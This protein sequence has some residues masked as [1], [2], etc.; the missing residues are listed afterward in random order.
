MYSF[1][2]YDTVITR[3]V[4]NP[5]GIWELMSLHL[6]ESIN[7]LEVSTYIAMNFTSIRESA[8]RQARKCTSKEVTIADIYRVLGNNYFLPKEALERLIL[9][10]MQIERD[11]AIL[12]TETFE[13]IKKLLKGGEEVI[14]ISDMY[15]PKSFFDQVFVKICPELCELDL[16]VSCDVG[17]T[18]ASGQMYKYIAGERNISYSDWNHEGDNISSDIHVAEL[19]GI[20]TTQYKRKMPINSLQRIEKILINSHPVISQLLLGLAKNIDSQKSSAY[21][22]GYSFV[23]IALYSYVEW[24][25]EEAL[26]RKIHG[27]C[28]VA[29]DGY[30]LKRIADVIINQNSK[31]LKTSYIYGSRM[32]WN[33]KNQD[34]KNLLLKYIKQE[35]GGNYDDIAF[36]ETQGTGSTMESVSMIL[37]C[38][39]K[40]FYYAMFGSLNERRILPI[41]YCNGVGGDIIEVLCRAPHG[42][43]LGYE[44][45][46]YH[47]VPQLGPFLKKDFDNINY[48][49]YWDGIEDFAKDYSNI[50]SFYK[51]IPLGNISETVLRYCLNTPDKELANFLGEIPF[52]SDDN[53]I[54]RKYA[55]KLTYKLLYEIE[56]NRNGRRLDSVYDGSELSISYSRLSEYD[57]TLLKKY[58]N[59]FAE[60]LTKKNSD[61][62][63]IV[64]YGFGKLGKEIFCRVH[65]N[66]DIDIIDIV[67]INSQN[68][69]KIKPRVNPIKNIKSDMYDYIIICIYDD[70]TENEIEDMLVIAGINKSKIISL[71]KFE[72]IL[73]KKI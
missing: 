18:K 28:F 31:K 7:E 59:E 42:M 27:L 38:K 33:P 48:F 17:K 6:I 34:E 66:P 43:T 68:F 13:K 73:D 4:N 50:C 71:K 51:N 24:V 3:K 49:D 32:A 45:K 53:N 62:K 20:N 25:I 11:N 60:K 37:N 36:V 70:K 9:L 5:K 41:C 35:V 23:G 56:L 39:L 21:T 67:D 12:I 14:L 52:D 65:L 54:T 8:E 30:I 58:R 10:E 44:E 64:L 46:G 2:V 63:R 26:K 69:D 55:P 29:R 1:D 16:Y 72:L 40:V 15:L 57:R 22:I 19:F 61:A 47:I